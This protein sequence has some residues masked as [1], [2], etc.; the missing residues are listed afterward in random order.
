LKR[1]LSRRKP[2]F[3]SFQNAEAVSHFKGGNFELDAQAS[4]VAVTVSASADA[5]YSRGKLTHKKAG[6]I[7]GFF[8]YFFNYFI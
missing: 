2:V 3:L 4:A 8:D 7:A 6:D 5:S 1:T